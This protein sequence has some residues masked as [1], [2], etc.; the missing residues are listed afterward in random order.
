[1]KLASKRLGALAAVAALAITGLLTFAG[2]A[3]AV[4]TIN[5]A[6]ATFPYPLY[7]QWAHDFHHVVPSIQINYSGIGSGGGIAAIE[8]GTVLFGGSDVPL[9]LADQRAH[10][11]VMFP[12]C[13]GGVVPIVN[14]S[15]VSAGR[16]KLTGDVLAKIYMGQIT[17]WNDSRIRAINPGLK[18]PAARIWTVHRSDASGTTWIFTHYL[19]AASKAWKQ[20]AN[21]SIVWPG[22]NAVGGKGNDGVASYVQKL[23]G[24]IGY[25][26]YAYARSNHIAWTQLKNR[27]ARWV[28]PSLT[29]FKA[30]AAHAAFRA[31]NGFYTVMVNASGTTAWPI[32]GATFILVRTSTSN[33]AK[34]HAMFRWFDWDLKNKVALK[35][36]TRLQYVSISSAVVKSIES[37]WHSKVKAGGK[38]AW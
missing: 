8:A 27:S 4:T 30:A 38:P 25:V 29:S 18:L 12:S 2:P 23:K 31:S 20:G 13:I 5:G 15:G 10:H 34:G 22:S 17:K 3:T 21:K 36:A 33:Y 37:V 6:G 35:D 26:E 11:L 28:L 9:T 32:T 19:K 14:I 7:V 16:L 24:A 1:M